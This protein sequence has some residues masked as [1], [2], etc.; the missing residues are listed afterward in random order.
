M[1]MYKMVGF[2]K[3]FS[4]DEFSIQ[5]GNL[6]KLEKIFKLVETEVSEVENL[7]NKARNLNF[8]KDKSFYTKP[9]NS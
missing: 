9:R 7:V 1:V 4:D 3:L 8:K 5:N 6:E 2:D